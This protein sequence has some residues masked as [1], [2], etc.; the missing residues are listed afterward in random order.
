M[1]DEEGQRVMGAL[2][3]SGPKALRKVFFLRNLE[4]KATS[5]NQIKHEKETEEQKKKKTKKRRK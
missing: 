3:L 1:P 4:L 2:G 5:Q